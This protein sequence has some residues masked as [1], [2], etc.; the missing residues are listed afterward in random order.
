M[1]GLQANSAI[2]PTLRIGM[3][4]VS[5]SCIASSSPE[6]QSFPPRQRTSRGDS[7]S[8]AFE[9]PMATE[10]LAVKGS[11]IVRRRNGVAATYVY[12]AEGNLCADAPNRCRCSDLA[13]SFDESVV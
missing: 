2:T 8:L 11:E 10:L 5:T 9:H 7:V 13:Q 1:S 4:K 6:V 12:G 3:S